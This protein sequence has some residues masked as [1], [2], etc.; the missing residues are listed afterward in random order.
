[1]VFVKV[2]QI[3]VYKLNRNAWLF[4]LNNDFLSVLSMNKLSSQ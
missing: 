3:F 2:K 1:M 4:V